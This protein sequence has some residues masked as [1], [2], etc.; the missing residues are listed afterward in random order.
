MAESVSVGDVKSKMPVTATWREWAGGGLIC[1]PGTLKTGKGQ[2]STQVPPAVRGEADVLG[3]RHKV[4]GHCMLV[5][6]CLVYL[7]LTLA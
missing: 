1:V 3:L 4:T 7:C 5:V 2:V 6:G